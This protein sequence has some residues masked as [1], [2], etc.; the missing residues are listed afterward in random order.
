MEKKAAAWAD[1][2]IGYLKEGIKPE[3]SFIGVEIEQF[4]V[5]RV[6]KKAVPYSG[7]GGVKEIVEKLMSMYPG[8]EPIMGED[9][10]GFT[11][12]HFTITLEPAAQI[13]ISIFPMHSVC[14]L[15]EISRDYFE[16]LDSILAPLGLEALFVGCQPESKVD[17]LELIPKE[18]YRLMDMHFQKTGTGGRQMMRGSASVQIS[19]DFTSEYD[20]RRK[21]QTA[22]FFAPAWMLLCNNAKRFQGED[23]QGYLKRYD[24]WDRT[25][26]AR[27]GILPG[28]FSDDYGFEDYAEFL[29]KMPM[30]F[31][32]EN[33]KEAYTG[34]KT[35]DEL[36]DGKVPDEAQIQ[37]ILSM[38]FPHV[39]V[40]KYLEIRV[41]DSVPVPYMLA[42]CSLVKGLMYSDEVLSKVQ[43]QIRKDHIDEKV[44]DSAFRD[45]MANGWDGSIFGHPARE[46]VQ[47]M[48]DTAKTDLSD[49]ECGYLEAFYKVLQFGGISEIPQE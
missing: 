2:V 42:Y 13:E 38:A 34:F 4:I 40:K 41:A 8:S 19:M 47:K 11:A 29:A 31:V 12:E 5:D 32:E 49:A 23:I 16:K 44:L 1:A 14:C 36:F 25:D 9:L 45:L 18:R 10:L 46:F 48:L 7:R 35:T 43:E 30:I 28:V 37:H 3:A 6:T 39:R 17:D 20:F 24:I 22:H 27:C 33:G 21:L 15:E 26:P